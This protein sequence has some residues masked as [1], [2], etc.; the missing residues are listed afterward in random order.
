MKRW[1]SPLRRACETGVRRVAS[2][3]PGVAAIEKCRVRKMG[4]DFYVD[5]H[6]EVDGDLSVHEGHRIAHEVKDAIR[7]SEPGDRRRAGARRAR[8]AAGGKRRRDRL[9]RSSDQRRPP[10]GSAPQTHSWRLRRDSSH[11]RRDAP[12]HLGTPLVTARSL[13]T[14]TL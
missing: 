5:I 9:A 2:A 11:L 7:E 3:V 12:I 14:E 13:R 10:A 4:L 1:T 8:E 6:V